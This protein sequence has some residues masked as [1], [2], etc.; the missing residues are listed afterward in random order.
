MGTGCSACGGRRRSQVCRSA[1]FLG[2]AGYY[3]LTP[4]V[5]VRTLRQGRARASRRLPGSGAVFA[6]RL[7]VGEPKARPQRRSPGDA[8]RSARGDAR[9]RSSDPRLHGHREVRGSRH[10]G[11]GGRAV[12][13]RPRRAGARGR[14]SRPRAGEPARA[15]SRKRSRAGRARAL[16]PRTRRET[17]DRRADGGVAFRRAGHGWGA[18]ADFRSTGLG[19]ARGPRTAEGS[20]HRR[21]PHVALFGRGRGRG[22]VGG[23]GPMVAL[24]H[25]QGPAGAGGAARAWRTTPSSPGT[26]TAGFCIGTAGPRRCTGGLRRRRSDATSTS[27]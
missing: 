26:R 4:V 27:Y 10:L 22:S 7:D 15:R 14:G 24:A 18:R 2:G 16:T 3:V 13:P 8:A 17:S 9:G 25:R 11:G 20:Q 6:R 5:V 1:V 12:A 19:D 21:A 23:R